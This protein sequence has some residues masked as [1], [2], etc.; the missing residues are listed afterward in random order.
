MKKALQFLSIIGLCLV[1]NPL[2]GQE[3]TTFLWDDFNGDGVQ[4]PGETGVGGA[5]VTI[6]DCGGTL[7]GALTDMGGGIYELATGLTVGAN[8]YIEYDFTGINQTSNNTPYDAFTIP[9]IDSDVDQGSGTI[10][11]SQTNQGC[12]NY[13]GGTYSDTNAGIYACQQISGVVFEDENGDDIQGPTEPG[14]SGWT[15]TIMDASCTPVTTECDGGSAYVNTITTNANGEYTFENLPPGDYIVQFVNQTPGTYYPVINDPGT[16]QE[17]FFND[18]DANVPGLKSDI[19][20]LVSNE[21]TW[22]PTDLFIGAGFYQT[23]CIR[24]TVQEDCDG[25]GE[26]YDDTGL[27]LAGWTVDLFD[28]NGAPVNDVNGNP[29][30]SV[31]TDG[32]GD[33]EFCDVIPGTYDIQLTMMADYSATFQDATGND[34]TDS[35]G[36]SNPY[37]FMEPFSIIDNV[38]IT[39][40]DPDLEDYDWGVFPQ[41]EFGGT[42]W[43]DAD[44]D[45]TLNGEAGVVNVEV[46]LYDCLGNLLGTVF[47]DP[48]GNYS[49]TGPPGQYVL[50]VDAANFATGGPL[51]IFTETATGGGANAFIDE[52]SDGIADGVNDG[53]ASECFDLYCDVM[54]PTTSFDFGFTSVGCDDPQISQYLVPTCEDL[55]VDNN[56]DMFGDL[57][58]CQLDIIGQFCG[59]MFTENSP[60]PQPNPLCNGGQVHNITWFAFVTPEDA[61]QMTID[62]Q[63]CIPGSDGTNG[64]QLGIYESCD[65]GTPIWCMVNTPVIGEVDIPTGMLVPGQV[66]YVFFDGWAGSA[67]SFELDIMGGTDPFV[68]PNADIAWQNESCVLDPATNTVCVGAFLDLWVPD[69]DNFALEFE[70]TVQTPAGQVVVVTPEEILA[71]FPFDQLGQYTFSFTVSNPCSTAGSNQDFIVTVVELDPIDFGVHPLCGNQ[72]WVPDDVPVGGVT[73]SWEGPN[74]SIPPNPGPGNVTQTETYMG[75]DGCGCTVEQTVEI[76]ILPDAM[77]GQLDTIICEYP[78]TINGETFNEGQIPPGYNQALPMGAVNGCDSSLVINVVKLEAIGVLTVSACDPDDGTITVEWSGNIDPS[79]SIQDI[80][81]DWI[82]PGTGNGLPSDGNANDEDYVVTN[83]SAPFGGVQLVGL[84]III[85]P[86]GNNPVCTKMIDFVTVEFPDV[87]SPDMSGPSEIC[88]DGMTATAMYTVDNPDP[89]YDYVWEVFG[90]G[91]ITAG[92]NTT[93]ATVDWAGAAIGDQICVTAVSDCLVESAPNCITINVSTGP[94]SGI[95]LPM[96]GCV[97]EEIPVEYDFTGVPPGSFSYVWDFD[98]GTTTAGNTNQ[99][100]PLNVVWSTPGTYTVSLTV[101]DTNVAGC[102][103]MGTATI[104]IQPEA[105]APVVDCG[106]STDTQVTFEWTPVAGATYTYAIGTAQTG[107]TFDPAAASLLVPVSAAGEQVD[108]TITCTVP[109]ECPVTE[110]YTCFAQNCDLPSVI[111]MGTPPD[112][113]ICLDGSEMPIQ[114]STDPVLDPTV[115]TLT[116][117]GTDAAGVFDPTGLPAGSYDISLQFLEIATGCQGVAGPYTINLIEVPVVNYMVQNSP[118][119]VGDGIEVSF[120]NPNNDNIVIVND[121]GASSVVNGTTANDRVFSFASA[122]TYT[123]TVKYE[124]ASCESAEVE[125]ELVVEDFADPGLSC[126][127]SDFSSVEF[128]WTEVAGATYTVNVI[129]IPAGALQSQTP[130]A[131][132]VTGLAQG[133][134]VEISLTVMTGNSCPD[135]TLGP[136]SC[137]ASDCPAYDVVIGSQSPMYLCLDSPDINVWGQI[138]D[139]TGTE[140][141]A[142]SILWTASPVPAAM[143]NPTAGEFRASIAGVGTHILTMTYTDPAGTCTAEDTT[144]VYVYEV[145]DVTIT[146]GDDTIC[147]DDIPSGGYVLDA[148]STIPGST[149]NWTLPTGVTVVSG[150]PNV[151]ASINVSFTPGATY[152]IGC[153][154]T[155]GICSSDLREVDITIDPAIQAPVISCQPSTNTVIFSW[156]PITNGT[157]T[158]VIELQGSGGVFDAGTNTYTFTG[159]TPGDI[160]EIELVIEGNGTSCTIANVG[161]GPCQAMVCP[162]IVVMPDPANVDICLEAGQGP[163]QL[164]AT[165]TSDGVPVSNPVLMYGGNTAVNATGLFDPALS[166][167]GTFNVIISYADANGCPGSALVDVR[168]RALPVA[169]IITMDGTV[170][171]DDIFSVEAN[172]NT[173]NATYNWVF[174][175]NVTGSSNSGAGP[176]ALSFSN[177]GTYEIELT[178]DDGNCISEP[179]FMM[180]TAEPTLEAPQIMCNSSLDE[181]NFTWNAVAGVTDYEVIVDGSSQGFQNTLGYD[182]GN[183]VE[184]QTVIFEVIAISNNSCPDVPASISCQAMACPPITFDISADTNMACTDDI[185]PIQLSVLLTGEDGTGSG[186]WTGNGVDANSGLVDITGLNAGSYTYNYDYQQG[187]CFYNASIA[188]EIVGSPRAIVDVQDPDCFTETTGLVSIA[189]DVVTAGYQISIDGSASSTQT[190]YDL[191]PGTYTM[192]LIDGNGCSYQETFT[193]TAATEPTLNISGNLSLI[194]NSENTF[195][196]TTDI[197]GTIDNIVWT[198]EGQVIGQGAELETITFD[199]GEK[200]DSTSQLCVEVTYNTDCVVTA[201]RDFTVRDIEKFYLA[202]IFSPNDDSYNDEFSI[203]SSVPGAVVETF[204]LYDRW[205]NL[206]KELPANQEIP[207]D[208]LLLWDGRFNNDLV[209]PGVYVYFIEIDTGLNS[210]RIS[211]DI[212]VIR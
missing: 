133:D 147:E 181:I 155:E 80:V 91:T 123:V 39:S 2:M 13:T 76:T 197:F 172:D 127:A 15:V 166:G 45:G 158:N 66:Y 17:Q 95:L 140:I 109:G 14:L 175:S 124:S 152:T 122:G 51:S 35:D 30:T 153:V 40:G 84:N 176:I 195:G 22:T 43:V 78:V 114:M 74:I 18:S 42:I 145:P 11:D 10:N 102:E 156:P 189:P 187:D 71:G 27:G 202:D 139:E 212:T 129:T 62:I 105:A 210:Y 200:R 125:I 50:D 115:F 90:N 148:S 128:T 99:P 131:F 103:A 112:T 87:P 67:C 75:T 58:L 190:D 23:V 86:I 199:S 146:N 167:P 47:T 180:V 132:T 186:M 150:D 52:D 5:T 24:G 29:I 70:W 149:F 59:T 107:E 48:M 54:N 113:E 206:M 34:A 183:L 49:F 16:T 198:D 111:L 207:E 44:M 120:D 60:G 184:G 31:V 36:L 134:L 101:D 182:V 108:V 165:V 138:F 8:Y 38:E 100:G 81:F 4:D 21:P 194:S 7:I 82:D 178:V 6:Y 171:V 77:P 89:T 94:P 72:V 56:N 69:Y 204:V 160:V 12:F 201:C 130:G 179:A 65:F 64:A 1:L 117:M 211:R 79:S 92:Q 28:G 53:V 41:M 192:T 142:G 33:Y 121:G 55:D 96:T 25:D 137:I 88:D 9:G 68:L 173:A 154:A 177:A 126:G 170:C 83:V 57:I 93:T 191:A 163:V 3:V 162:D 136:I 168:V 104:T 110:T 37:N 209:L 116:W 205:G 174:P 106:N 20:T 98:T 143:T 141:V 151:D 119:C 159:L 46:N 193:V 169:D 97:G 118:A 85:T 208:G 185:A 19:Y 135:I 157:L 196:F 63:S 144:T 203:F 26:L 61:F 32:N 73:Y 161:S 188:I 164:S